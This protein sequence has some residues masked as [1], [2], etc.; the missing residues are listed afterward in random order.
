[1]PRLAFKPDSSFFRKIVIGAVGARAVIADLAGNGH[2]C[3]ELERGSTDTKLWKDIKRKRVRIPDLV[4]LNCGARI[5]CRA[6]T[7][8]ELAMS[9]SATDAERAWDF[10]MVDTDWIAFPVCQAVHDSTWS[11][12]SLSDAV[13]Y[14]REKSC[15]RWSAAGPISY[16]PVAAFRTRLHA[17]SRVKGVEEGSENVIAWRA[18]FSTRAGVVEMIDPRQNLLTIRRTTDGHKHTWCVPGDHQIVVSLGQK[19]KMGELVAS[20]VAPVSRDGLHCPGNFTEGHIQSLLESRERTQRFTG[21]KLARLCRQTTVVDAVRSLASDQEEDIYVRLEAV[22]YLTSVLSESARSLFGPFLQSQ[23]EQ[24]Q[25]ET[26][27]A[28]GESA[29]NEA[30][31]LLCEIVSDSSHPFFLRSAAAWSLSQTRTEAASRQLVRAFSDVDPALRE[32][33]LEGLAMIGS[34][35][36]PALF[37][38]LRHGD[39]NVNAGCAEALRRGQPHAEH[40]VDRLLNELRSAHPQ[41][42]AVWLVGHL[43]R[44]QFASA[45]AGLQA[46]KPELHYAVSLLWSFVESWIARH[47]ELRPSARLMEQAQP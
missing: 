24:G 27:I 44:E 8:L 36:I 42:W 45:I 46:D 26:V 32:E 25:L 2:R 30:I 33:A 5:E 10:G 28:L 38:G 29:S 4:C 16:F 47:W 18:I 21:V 20:A 19:V 9:H 14:W 43:P 31:E 37:D 15:V 13:S 1:M 34:S 35:A 11:S 17:R 3:V 22:S 39:R 7:K 41:T 40:V 23:D 6:K 12:G